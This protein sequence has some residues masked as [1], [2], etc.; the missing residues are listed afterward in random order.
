[1]KLIFFFF[2]CLALAYCTSG[3]TSQ[4]PQAN[5]TERQLKPS[6]GLF[7]DTLKSLNPE[8]PAVLDSAVR[9]YDLLAPAD[10]TGA[11][12]AASTL[13]AFVQAVTEIQNNQLAKDTTNY[14]PL[15]DVA[16]TDL[17]DKQKA[18]S[19]DLHKAKLKLVGDGEGGVYVTPA[20]ETI[21]PTVKAKTSS[22]L[23]DCLDLTAKEDTM[24][25]FLDAGLAVEVTELVD[26]LVKSEN[27]VAQSLP[28]R[29]ANEAARLNRFYTRALIRGSDNSPAL[30]DD[31]ITLTES[32]RQG[33]DYL[34]TKYPQSKASARLNV[35]TAVVKSGDKRKIE[36]YLKLLDD[37]K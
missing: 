6:L 26:L 25:S 1:M 3:D 13:M 4:K 27:L 21:L 5:P 17:T 22:A 37:E 34:L 15:L 18:L 9:L 31:G 32:F 28:R 29:F 33:Y 20:Y 35:W 30:E 14:L 16:T 11:D 23:D 8:A 7:I 24:P 36:D 2:S 12:S 19:S 10:S